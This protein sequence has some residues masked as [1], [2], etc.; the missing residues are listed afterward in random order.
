[1]CVLIHHRN[2]LGREHTIQMNKEIEMTG[3]Y[4]VTVA[5]HTPSILCEKHARAFEQHFI[6]EAIAHTIYE[7]DEDDE[8]YHC[9]FPLKFSR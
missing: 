6:A 3:R 2:Q 7:M 9:L 5:E 4:L 8:H 1:M